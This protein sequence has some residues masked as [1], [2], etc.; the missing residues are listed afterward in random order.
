M[1]NFTV[2]PAVSADWEGFY[3]FLIGLDRPLDSLEAA[4]ERFE[5]KINSSLHRVLVAELEGRVVGIAMAHEWDE[6]L[7]SGRKQ[8]R[9]GTLYVLPAFQKRGIGKALF[10][11]ARDWAESIGATWFE[12]YA[13]QSAVPFYERLGYTGS[14]QSDPDHPY[15]EILFK[16]D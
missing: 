1:S 10:E 3:P 15:F 7:M 4:Q 11:A 2:R 9:F 6:Y 14:A 16:R 5:R 12:W 13:S 8:I